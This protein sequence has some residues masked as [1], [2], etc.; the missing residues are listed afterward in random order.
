MQ[1]APDRHL[2]AGGPAIPG[3]ADNRQP[4]AP[5][6]GVLARLVPRIR[7]TSQTRLDPIAE[8]SYDL[9]E[10]LTLTFHHPNGEF[11][12]SGELYRVE[13]IARLDDA[14]IFRVV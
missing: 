10:A 14:D 1:Q 7:A 9:Q 13:L 12:L 5:P 2:P 4:T 8:R 11:A 3:N 6:R